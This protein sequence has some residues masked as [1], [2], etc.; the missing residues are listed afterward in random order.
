MYPDYG[1]SANYISDL[2]VWGQLS[3]HIFNPSVIL[4][5]LLTIGGA[6]F[7]LI[8]FRMRGFTLIIA[9]SGLSGLLVGFFPENIVLVNGFPSFTA[10][11][12]S[13]PLFSEAYLQLQAIV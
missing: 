7:I 12:R 9:L 6:F 4:S 3:A 1:V 2:G 13:L 8:A 5:G 10:L 11:P